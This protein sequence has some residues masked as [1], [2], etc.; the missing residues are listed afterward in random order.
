MATGAPLAINDPDFIQS[1]TVVDPE[2]EDEVIEVDFDYPMFYVGEKVEIVSSAMLDFYVGKLKNKNAISTLKTKM[3]DGDETIYTYT[4]TMPDKAITVK[5]PHDFTI[6]PDEDESSPFFKYGCANENGSLKTIYTLSA[7]D[8][9]YSGEAVTASVIESEVTIPEELELSRGEISYY[10]SGN[11]LLSEAPVEAGTYIAKVTVSSALGE[12]TLEKEFT[13]AP[14]S[15]TSGDIFISISNSEKTYDGTA[16]TYSVDFDC[17][18]QDDGVV[19]TEPHLSYGD[20]YIITVNPDKVI[21]GNYTIRISGI[22]NYKDYREF[23][24]AITE[25]DVADQITFTVNNKTYDG[26]VYNNEGQLISVTAEEGSLAES[27]LA[28]AENTDVVIEFYNYDENA[29]NN[30]YCGNEPIEPVNAGKYVA[31]LTI[32]NNN[33]TEIVKYREFE[34]EK[35]VVTVAPVVKEFY[36]GTKKL[37]ELET[38]DNFTYTCEIGFD[39]SNLPNNYF[40]VYFGDTPVSADRIFENADNDSFIDA[41]QYTYEFN[42]DAELPD[43]MNNYELVWTEEGT[44]NGLSV[45]MVELNADRFTV[46]QGNNP[47]YNGNEQ[48]PDF[49][50]VDTLTSEVLVTWANNTESSVGV[51]RTGIFG[52]EGAET[53]AGTG[54]EMII[55]PDCEHNYIGLFSFGYVINPLSI[56]DGT[57]M[58]NGFTFGLVDDSLTYNGEN[59]EPEVSSFTY[60][61]GNINLEPA[62]DID[63]EFD[64]DSA[65][66]VGDEYSYTVTGKG[67]YT[68]SFTGTWSIDQENAGNVNSIVIGAQSIVYN[69][70]NYDAAN[71]ELSVAGTDPLSADVLNDANNKTNNGTITYKYVG[72]G[73]TQ[74]DESTTA[75][76]NIGT[77]KVTAEITTDNIKGTVTVSADFSITQ[78]KLNVS[79]ANVSKEFG[80]VTDGAVTNG[81]HYKSARAWVVD[82]DNITLTNAT[83][84]GY[85]PTADDLAAVKDL[86]DVVTYGEN[87]KSVK[88]VDT[89]KDDAYFLKA[90]TYQYTLTDNHIGNFS[91]ELVGETAFTVTKKVSS[92]GWIFTDP[93]YL[94][95]DGE[96][97]RVVVKYDLSNLWQGYD[98]MTD[99][100][101][102]SGN[103][104][105]N[106]GTYNVVLTPVDAENGNI[107]PSICT[108]DNAKHEWTIAKFEIKDGD[109]SLSSN[110]EY[111]K[112]TP[113]YPSITVKVDLDSDNSTE[114]IGL[115]EGDDKDYTVAYYKVVDNVET[116]INADQ[117]VNVG[118]YR[119]KVT[120]IGNYTGTISK[121]YTI[122]KSEQRVYVIPGNIVYDGKIVDESDFTIESEAGNQMG[123]VTLEFFTGANGVGKLE[124]APINAGTYYVRATVAASDNYKAGY[125]NYVQF[126]IQK[127][128]VTITPAK[129]N[130]V[131]YGNKG[132]LDSTVL[133]YSVELAGET[134]N[135]GFIGTENDAKELFGDLLTVGKEISTTNVQHTG[136]ADNYDVTIATND[137]GT[138]EYED[139]RSEKQIGEIT[140]STHTALPFNG[141]YKYGYSFQLYTPDEIGHAHAIDS[142]SYHVQG[143]DNLAH[144]FDIYLMDVDTNFTLYAGYEDYFKADIMTKVYSTDGYTFTTGWNEFKFN[145]DYSHEPGKQVLVLFVNK[146]GSFNNNNLQ[147]STFGSELNNIYNYSDS[148]QYDFNV[149]EQQLYEKTN[150]YKNVI[151]LGLAGLQ[152]SD[153]HPNYELVLEN[154]DNNVFTVEKKDLSTANITLKIGRNKNGSDAIAVTNNT[155]SFDSNRYYVFYDVNDSKDND[156]IITEND[157]EAFTSY[158]WKVQPGTYEYEF[159]A[160]DNGNYTGEPVVK[161][162][163]I[164]NR[165]M[166]VTVEVAEGNFTYTGE[167]FDESKLSVTTGVGLNKEELT[168][169]NY[170]ITYKYRKSGTEDDFV[171]GAP[172]NAGEY[173]VSAEITANGTLFNVTTATLTIEKKTITFVPTAT[174]YTKVYGEDDPEYGYTFTGIVD[175]D[176]GKE[177]YTGTISRLNAAAHEDANLYTNE[178]F[179]VSGLALTEEGAVN[180]V[181]GPYSTYFTLDIKPCQIKPENLIIKTP[182]IAY[183]GSLRNVEYEVVVNG[184]TVPA[185]AYDVSGNTGKKVGTYNLEISAEGGNYYT[186]GSGLKQLD[187]DA[188]LPATVTVYDMQGRAIRQGVDAKKALEGL[189]NGLY[190]IG[191]KKMLK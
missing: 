151:K 187:A 128:W 68:G 44:G 97:K 167:A 182:K 31:K 64:T 164:T 180:Y 95:Y 105:T 32:T 100:V 71:I 191:G 5:H 157:Y 66:I 27:L 65:K 33:Y 176:A 135:T 51:R 185:S 22:N 41:G 103:I 118:N 47:T 7:E 4:F 48:S 75:P 117:F 15:F 23:S 79:I 30:N 174:S 72:T 87:Y 16:P 140:D 183:T 29:S 67:N 142:I 46:T 144:K 85:D 119:I 159:D 179:D 107:D 96:E 125:S 99:E 57:Q 17:N 121:D 25:A 161:E 61:S 114:K 52:V 93:A 160:E 106:A 170:T 154:P 18:V 12:R 124:P 190:I 115:E 45:N 102:V 134:G 39:M 80:T 146:T 172:V 8:T 147:F 175:A 155:V 181:I 178:K 49:F 143:T 86:V 177:I 56:G 54:Y 84:N 19:G 90:G 122:L 116:L 9:V 137:A 162:W 78:L 94:T 184:K 60:A 113:L 37:A 91:V 50:F 36:Y 83:D 189:P 186:D 163:T 76:E 171:A 138:Y 104:A 3:E 156:S 111:Y 38:V 53:D 82:G 139:F 77:Y 24:Y 169:P 145:S 43:Y 150:N 89:T 28:D 92:S 62:L 40:K 132:A 108:Y 136:T 123:S 13:I 149:P 133:K 21:V 34:I 110:E 63:Y 188:Q 166:A 6:S 74:Y 131:T 55:T 126:T 11:T 70:S 109:V 14:K 98:Y 101:V 69:G 35:A 173:E 2:D 153:S 158:S 120:G 42:A 168:A 141:R 112:G 127:R 26:A 129:D 1:M 148:D 152:I 59:Q 10:N 73:D 88:N 81:D 165:Q 130:K 58:A 20:D